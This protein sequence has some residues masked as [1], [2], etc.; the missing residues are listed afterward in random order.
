MPDQGI[1]VAPGQYKGLCF[2]PRYEMALFEYAV[3]EAGKSAELAFR[4]A[5]V[6]NQLERPLGRIAIENPKAPGTLIDLGITSKEIGVAAPADGRKLRMVLKD[7]SGLRT[8]ERL[9]KIEP[10]QRIA[11]RW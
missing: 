8:E 1:R 4:W 7:D 5:I 11:V 6:E 2:S 10:G 9:V 3:V